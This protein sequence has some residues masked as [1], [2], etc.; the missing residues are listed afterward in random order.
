M[1]AGGGA[2]IDFNR[3]RLARLIHDTSRQKS[4][5]ARMIRASTAERAQLITA[6]SSAQHLLARIAASY[7]VLLERLQQEKNFHKA[8]Q[9][10]TELQDLDE[11]I[12]RRNELVKQFEAIRRDSAKP[13]DIG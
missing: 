2:L 4:D 6:L 11:M 12:H 3:Y 8:C 9:A 1:N 13:L 10:A 5:V 7:T